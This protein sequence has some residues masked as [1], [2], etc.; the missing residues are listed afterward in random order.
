MKS[1][2]IKTVLAVCLLNGMIIINQAHAVPNTNAG[3]GVGIDNPAAVKKPKSKKVTKKQ[4]RKKPVKRQTTT[5]APQAIQQVVINNYSS[6]EETSSQYWA[7][8]RDRQLGLTV[9]AFTGVE[10]TKPITKTSSK[11]PI[12][13]A[14]NWVGYDAR[15]DRAE[16]S[17]FLS[18]GNDKRV[19]PVYTAWC[20]AF[21]NAVLK[22]TGR[23]GTNSL[24]AR[25]FLAYG[26][27]VNTP[28]H[29][30][31]VV[32]KRGRSSASGHVAFFD[33]IEYIGNRKYI[34]AVGG[35]QNKAVTVALYPADRLLGIRRI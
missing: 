6:E 18:K 29:G 35:N 24:M 26:T 2:L 27:V 9:T 20:A 31:I 17:A 28:Q 33:G 10:N 5:N 34:R 30:D 21:M 23:D 14:K 13:Q 12:S 16:L 25:S 1:T 22:S 8:E 7:R 32:F 11:K 15:K 4:Q 19:D 3:I